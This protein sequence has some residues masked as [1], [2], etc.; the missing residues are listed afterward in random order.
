ME[1]FLKKSSII[2][3]KIDNT[4]KKK[5]ATK[6]KRVDPTTINGMRSYMDNFIVVVH[7]KKKKKKEKLDKDITF[8]MDI[9]NGNEIPSKHDIMILKKK[10]E[11]AVTE[12]KKKMEL[13]NP[14]YEE[15]ESHLT[16]IGWR[17]MVRDEFKKEYFVKLKKKLMREKVTFHPSIVDTFEAFNTCPFKKTKVIIIGQDPYH[18]YGQAHGLSFS[19]KRGIKTPPSLMNIFTELDNTI[20]TFDV[21]RHGCLM[22]WAS[23][24]VLLL[25]SVLTVQHGK[26]ASHSMIGWTSFTNQVIRLLDREKSH[27]VF[28]LWG[29]KAQNKENILGNDKNHLILKSAHP[30]PY[31]VDGFYGND[32]FNKCN[33]YLREHNIKEIN[34]SL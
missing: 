14:K 16:E 33:R 5:K 26:P 4:K 6:K 15:L 27:L 30:S 31:S 23:Q 25:N 13:R 12:L 32:H 34:W 10:K 21:P 1:K 3:S 9:S 11:Y 17:S 24:G 18:G 19:V 8:A 7:K 28:M 29:R 2:K 22:A 20:E